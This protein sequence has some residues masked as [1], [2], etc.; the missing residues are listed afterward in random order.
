LLIV[1]TTMLGAWSCT[2]STG[3]KLTFANPGSDWWTSAPTIVA[4]ANK[5]FE[6]ARLDLSVADVSSG[7]AS[8]NAVA[9]GTADIGLTAATP[10]ALAASHNEPIVVIGTYLRSNL[11]VGVAVPAGSP[12]AGIPPSPIAVVP[13]TI[14]EWYLYSLLAKQ[15]LESD[16][17]DSKF[18]RLEVRPPDVVASVSGGSAKSAV[19]WEPFLTMLKRQPGVEVRRDPSIQEV[20]LFLVT[21]PD[22]IAS[23]RAELTRFIRAFDDSCRF[24]REHSA[25]AKGI[26]ERHYG[27]DS[28]MMADAWPSVT[29][30]LEQNV[31]D[32]K[33]AIRR[34]A[35]IALR[36]K[37]I[38]AIPSLDYLFPAN[39]PTVR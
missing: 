26:V 21:R 5:A 4:S 23:K 15:G 13:G 31:E 37:R 27:F 7:L 30:G 32:M 20:R 3:Q 10:L 17:I 22:V 35:N 8:K 16:F 11:V 2:G 25:E 38:A 36:L 28:E 18:A 33:A 19:I 6:N 34:E 14:S 39:T 9:A 1:A 29:Y 12:A 24:I